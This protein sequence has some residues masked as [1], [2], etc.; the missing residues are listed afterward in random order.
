MTGERSAPAQET[1]SFGPF[2]LSSGERI[3][4]RDGLVLPLG[5]RALD[6]LI[7]LVGRA[8]EVVTKEELTDRAWPDIVVEEGSLRVHVAAIRKALRDGQFENRY[9][10]NIKG[11]GYC[12]VAPVSRLSAAGRP[13]DDGLISK[14]S[15]AFPPRLG[16]MIGRE[17]A[18]DTISA[19]LLTGRFVSIVGSGGIGKTTVAVS[20][21]RRLL[22]DAELAVFV[23]G[24]GIVSC[25]HAELPVDAKL[26]HR[27]RTTKRRSCRTT[28]AMTKTDAHANKPTI[29]TPQ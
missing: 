25:A 22:E 7:C 12:F 3:L 10:T 9:I 23:R 21:R 29:T 18:V 5:G 2:E 14:K 17:R 28:W 8:G 1:I 26:G 19:Q 6:I 24:E 4:R 27:S 20:V 16:R 15:P 11:R 13:V